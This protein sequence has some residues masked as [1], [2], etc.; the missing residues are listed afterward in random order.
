MYILRVYG[1]KI[2]VKRLKKVN[3]RDTGEREIYD[4]K[5]EI[6]FY[7]IIVTSTKR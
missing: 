4:D 5:Y 6:T 2:V 1:R 7:F 3:T